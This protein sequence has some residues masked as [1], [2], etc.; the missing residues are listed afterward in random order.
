[1]GKTTRSICEIC[2]TKSCL[3][4]GKPCKEVEQ[5]L[6][7]DGIRSSNYIRPENSKKQRKKWGRYKEIPFSSLHYD[8][9]T[10]TFTDPYKHRRRTIG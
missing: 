5:I 6:R 4:T 7:S 1:M 3:Q 10:G 9:E 8:E 2:E